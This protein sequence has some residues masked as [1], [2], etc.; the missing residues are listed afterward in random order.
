MN[1]S[2]CSITG[3]SGIIIP[4]YEQRRDDH[5]GDCGSHYRLFD[6]EMR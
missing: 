5:A 4:F 6:E 2:I 1:V 3:R